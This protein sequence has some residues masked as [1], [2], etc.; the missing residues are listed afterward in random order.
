MK[1]NSNHACVFSVKSGTH[2]NDQGQHFSRNSA[3]ALVLA[4]FDSTERYDRL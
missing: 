2:Q 3:V 4:A 1:T